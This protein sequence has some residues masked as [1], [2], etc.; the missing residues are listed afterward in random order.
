MR[1]VG[2]SSGAIAYGDFMGALEILSQT[3]F[4]CLELSALS[5]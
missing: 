5:F 1:N 2:F 3:G 4:P